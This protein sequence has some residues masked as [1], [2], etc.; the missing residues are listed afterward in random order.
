VNAETLEP[1][2]SAKFAFAGPADKERAIRGAREAARSAGFAAPEI[3]EL[4]LVV[5][6]LASNAIKYGG[7]D[8]EI[9][10]ARFTEGADTGIEIVYASPL[11]FRPP[12]PGEA[13]RASPG[14]GLEVIRNHTDEFRLDPG[15][16][17]GMRLVLRKVRRRSGPLAFSADVSVLTAPAEGQ[18]WNG[19]GFFVECGATRIVLAAFDAL[20]HGR[21]AFETSDRAR[22]ACLARR[23]WGIGPLVQKLQDT[24]ENSR[25]MALAAA[26]VD[27]ATGAGEYTGIGNVEARWLRSDQALSLVPSPGILGKPGQRIRVVPFRLESPG[28]LLLATDG[29]SLRNLEQDVAAA[30]PARPMALATDLMERRGR[31]LDD[32]TVVAARLRAA[33]PGRVEAA[34]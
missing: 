5:G 19:D 13:P 9:R 2:A 30:D 17:Q 33:A 25:G 22:K 12:V 32:R 28:L 27:L 11:P 21:G 26:S 29:I 3:E 15:E 14:I 31:P 6:E 24:L 4:A 1:P 23:G 10:L 34:P 20:G 7:P 16:E 18:R 8:A